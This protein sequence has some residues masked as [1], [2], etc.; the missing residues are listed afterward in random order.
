[1]MSNELIAQYQAD[2]SNKEI[3]QKLL[4]EYGPYIKSN[5]N[6]WTGPIPQAVLEAHGK[7]YALEAFKTFNPEKAAIHT[8]LYN[9]LSQVS[10]LIY[11]HANASKIPENQILKIGKINSAKAYLNDQ[12]GYEPS[13]DEIADHLHLPVTHIEKII[14][15][16]HA[17]FINDSDTEFQQVATSN[18]D[19]STANRIFSYRNSLDPEKQKQFDALTGFNNSPILSPGQIGKKFKMKPYEVSRLKTFFAK[20]IK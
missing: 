10:R 2:P 19:N 12:L 3:E 4:N 7:H 8:H 18:I 15:N 20:G 13:I 16:Q 14:K 11:E 1:M 6:K 9:N 17:D 5:I